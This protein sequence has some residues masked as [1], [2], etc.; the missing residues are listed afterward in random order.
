MRCADEHPSHVWG[1]NFRPAAS[2]LRALETGE[3]GSRRAAHAIRPQQH[4]RCAGFAVWRSEARRAG[5][6]DIGERGKRR[7][8]QFNAL[9]SHM[10]RIRIASTTGTQPTRRHRA[11]AAPVAQT[12]CSSAPPSC[13][14]TSAEQEGEEEEEEDRHT[15]D[16]DQTQ[17]RTGGPQGYRNAAGRT[18]IPI[19]ARL[20]P[21]RASSTTR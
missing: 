14:A 11:V 2:R 15:R 1:F 10:D 12:D 9:H 7:S 8:L 18:P 20:P 5:Q 4:V 16:H 17:M 19:G 6:C 21:R 3:K 13:L